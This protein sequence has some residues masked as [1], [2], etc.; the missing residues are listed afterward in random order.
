MC[1]LGR[2]DAG[3]GL[4]AVNRG[5]SNFRPLVE[6]IQAFVKAASSGPPLLPWHSSLLK[7]GGKGRGDEVFVIAPD[8]VSRE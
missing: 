5:S 1:S 2:I 6:T 7:A 3:P 8:E 4:F